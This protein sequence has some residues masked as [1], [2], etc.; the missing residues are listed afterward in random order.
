MRWT[1]SGK[2]IALLGVNYAV[3]FA[4]GYRAIGYVGANHET[5]IDR[6][7]YHFARMGLDAYRIHIWDIEIS[8]KQGDL[9]ENDHLRLLDY[10]IMRLKERGIKIVLTTMRNSDNAFPEGNDVLGWGFSRYYPK[11]LLSKLAG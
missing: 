4:H 11:S 8:N 6:D 10:L 3:P 2:E 7:V 9:V 5:T 1:S